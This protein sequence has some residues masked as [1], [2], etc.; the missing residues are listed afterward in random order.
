MA[1]TFIHHKASTSTPINPP[2]DSSIVAPI[3]VFQHGQSQYRSI[4]GDDLVGMLVKMKRMIGVSSLGLFEESRYE[5][6]TIYCL[7][8]T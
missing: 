7:T 6:R 4:K 3:V 8:F 1:P 5:E 2:D